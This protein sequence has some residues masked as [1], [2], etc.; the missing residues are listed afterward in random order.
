LT[1]VFQIRDPSGSK[2]AADPAEAISQKDEK[3]PLSSMGRLIALDAARGIAIIGMYLQHFA[4]NE[5]NGSIV[6]GNTALLFL[7]CGGISY[8]IMA[9]RMKEKNNEGSE[10]RARMLARAVFIDIT[11]YLV[12]M[13]NTPFGVILPAYS[14]LFV[15]ALILV[16]R[17]TRVLVT[18][19]IGLLLLGPPL[20]ILG[21][22]AFS[23]AYFLQDIAGGPMSALG[24]AP[25]FAAGMV[26]GRLDF[27]RIRTLASIVVCGFMMFITGKALAAYV[28]PEW[29]SSFELWLVSIRGNNPS[30]PDPYAIW[31]LN[32]DFPLWHMLLVN[33]PHSASTFQTSIGLGLSLMVVGLVFL[34]SQKLTVVL[35][36]FAAL[37]RVALTMYVLQFIVVWVIVITGHDYNVTLPL[38]DLIVAAVTLMTGWLIASLRPTGPLESLMRYFDRIF[39]PPRSSTYK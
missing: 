31:P 36:P 22:S 39:S 7:L 34:L 10:F 21:G 23:G 19:T 20:M 16:N 9:Q 15:L 12:I 26:I 24:L 3:K 32:T 1:D 5:R 2:Q 38:A 28:L 4:L 37:G 29:R 27:T 30:P 8:S 35:I 18:T 6:S 17:S 33:A 14:A 11:G 13:L 25:A